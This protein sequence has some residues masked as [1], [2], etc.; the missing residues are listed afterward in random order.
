M[1]IT[2]LNI[3]V[4]LDFQVLKQACMLGITKIH[5][6]GLLWIHTLAA[7]KNWEH[8]TDLY[9]VSSLFGLFVWQSEVKVISSV[10]FAELIITPIRWSVSIY[11]L[12]LFFVPLPNI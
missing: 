1:V 7:I 4:T 9:I 5:I 3:R 6:T 2:F 11:S 8:L 12:A 10:N